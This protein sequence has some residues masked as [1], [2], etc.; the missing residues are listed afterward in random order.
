MRY[1]VGLGMVLA[2]LVALPLRGITHVPGWESRSPNL[3][4]LMHLHGP[5]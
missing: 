5:T 3:A 4:R 1:L 2:G